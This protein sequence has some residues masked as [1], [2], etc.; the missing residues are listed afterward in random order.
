MLQLYPALFASPILYLMNDS[1]FGP[2]NDEKF[3]SV[4]RRVRF[5]RADVVGLTDGS[6]TIGT[7]KAFPCF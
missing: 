1:L 2:L 5:S 6:N 7:F 4:L 3:A